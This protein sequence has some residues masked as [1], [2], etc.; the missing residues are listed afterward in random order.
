MPDGRS[1]WDSRCDELG[2][3]ESSVVG[4]SLSSVAL[5]GNSSPSLREGA[6]RGG[7]KSKTLLER[8]SEG[9]RETAA[10]GFYSQIPV[11]RVWLRIRVAYVKE[12]RPRASVA[13]LQ[14]KEGIHD[15]G[16]VTETRCQTGSG[17]FRTMSGNKD[18][19][20]F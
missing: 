4:T 9:V 1:I 20:S 5:G 12:H 2:K 8:E 13:V 18:R 10:V 15:W 14:Q 11:V 16:Q 7:K 19:G 6:R 3:V 17:N